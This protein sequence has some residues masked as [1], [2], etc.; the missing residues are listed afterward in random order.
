MRRVSCLP[1]LSPRRSRR[2]A[3]SCDTTEYRTIGE[4]RAA[5]VVEPEDA[6]HQLARGIEARDQLA[7]RID[8]LPLRID[9]QAAKAERNAAGHRVGLER[10]C[11]ERIRPVGLV[12]VQALGATPVLH[13]G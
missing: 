3:G 6:A 11:I 9:L 7:V 10:R 5:W 4:P 1:R 13:V 12:D 2:R 8:D